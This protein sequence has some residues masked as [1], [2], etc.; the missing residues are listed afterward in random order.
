[1]SLVDLSIK[2]PVVATVMAL[3]LIAFGIVS[4][5]RIPL[6]E[7][8]DIDPPVVTVET[9]Y[10]GAAASIVETRVTKIL[11]DRIAGIEGINFIESKSEEG[12]STITV[13]FVSGFDVS[14]AANDVRDR[15]FGVLDELPEEADPPEIRKVD[16]NED[17]IV[18]FNLE[19][20]GLS[21]AEL[22]D[23]SERYLVD[24]FSSLQ[25]VARVRI[26]GGQRFAARIWLDRLALAARG[27]SVQEVE[28]ALKRGNVEIP[29]GSIESNALQFSVVVERVFDTPESLANLVISTHG[30]ALVR[31]SD[32][33]RVERSTEED[34]STFRGNGMPMV[35]LGIIKQATANTIDVAERAQRLRDAINKELPEGME[36]KQS[37]DASIFVSE[38]VSEVYNTLWLATLLV[39]AVMYFFLRDFRATLVPAVTVPISLIATFIALNIFGFSANILTLLA[40]VLAIGIVV[41]DA[42]VV[43]ENIARRMSEY[44]ETALVAAF[45]GT[46]EV[47][48]AV[49]ATT[50]VLVSVFAPLAFLEGDLGRLFSEFALTMS[51]AVA[52][53]TFVALSFSPMIASK[54]LKPMEQAKPINLPKFTSLGAQY[55]KRVLTVALFLV[56][57][58]AALYWA[59][60]SEYAPRED[61][62]AFFVLVNGPE[63]ASFSY[64]ANAMGKVEDVMLPYVASGE[65][66]RLLVRAP[67]GF[68]GAQ[69]YNNGIV[70]TVLNSFDKRR[71]AFV[72]M[73]EIT[74][75]L[76]DIAEVRAFPVMRQ[77]FGRGI[78]KPV[79]VVM[80]GSSYE[81]LATWRDKL[82]E[83]INKDNP[84]LEGIDWDYKETKPEIRVTVDYDKAALLGVTVE[85]IGRSLETLLGSRRVTTYI[86]RGEEYDIILEGLRG[87]QSS[88][89]DILGIY[90]AGKDSLVPLSSLVSFREIASSP[91]L[92]RFN[93][94]RAITF[95]ANL[96]KDLSLGEALDFL[97]NKITENFQATIDF[98]GQSRDFKTSE[99]SII[100]VFIFG[101][102]V[103][104]LVLA[105]QFE[106]FIHPLVILL[107]VPLA[108]VGGLLG[109]L[110]T[111]GSLNIYSQVGLIVLV[112]LSAK[113]GILIVE[114]ANQLRER[115]IEFKEALL[116]AN[117][118]RLRPIL[119]TGIT[120]VAGAVPLVLTTGAG[121]ETRAAV[122]AVL[123]FGVAFTTIFTPIIIPAAYIL[124]ARNTGTPKDVERRLEEELA[125][126]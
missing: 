73:D 110:V 121:S 86:D 103:V 82:L 115:G 13:Q 109:I 47:Y 67:R 87:Q 31:L 70:I 38:A 124:F 55:P 41:D 22:T 101:I 42:I 39:I 111:G 53:S 79:Q 61:R 23:Y 64:T 33:A 48:F 108:I 94:T 89:Q 78:Q 15:V 14:S 119:M 114:F 72:I 102:I 28:N 74:K 120:T 85:D 51:A 104:Y 118:T 81:E 16:S 5:K 45:R 34:R 2:R 9:A 122:G 92:N 52:F 126:K 71:S 75:K 95:E 19:G 68:G 113:N 26:G 11:E 30:S 1:M 54:I 107:T 112:G 58:A 37:Y 12:Q 36:L 7:Y 18:W 3:L 50:V 43:L 40:L 46:K 98:K 116:Q 29:A 125:R 66:T 17:V 105:A 49:I 76:A 6:R 65:V 106:S 62:G 83:V 80:G 25:G 88:P 84:G 56:P 100:F 123:L 8:P 69:T 21:T 117:A 32:V 44:K 93:R 60:P 63:G 27:I 97:Q 57:V 90:V 24:R 77:G 91:S 10:R 96:S 4:F 99:G 59:S 35:G 20:E